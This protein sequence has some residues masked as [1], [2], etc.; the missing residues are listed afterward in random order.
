[1]A[2]SC[3]LRRIKG[4]STEQLKAIMDRFCLYVNREDGKE[5]TR[6]DYIREILAFHKSLSPGFFCSMIGYDTIRLMRKVWKKGERRDGQV[7]YPGRYIYREDTPGLWDLTSLALADISDEGVSIDETVFR[8]IQGIPREDLEL[9]KS[10]EQVY[11]IAHRYLLFWGIVDE[12]TLVTA[13]LRRLG[14]NSSDLRPM[15][16]EVILARCGSRSVLRDDDRGVFYLA[17]EAQDDDELLSVVDSFL[18][19]KLMYAVPSD[20]DLLNTIRLDPESLSDDA[21]TYLRAAC[22]RKE[23]PKKLM[24]KPAKDVVLSLLDSSGSIQIG[25][26][27]LERAVRLLRQNIRDEAWAILVGGIGKNACDTG[28]AHYAIMKLVL[29]TPMWIYK[30]KTLEDLSTRPYSSSRPYSIMAV[31]AAM[32]GKHTPGFYDLCPCGSCRL[33][34]LCHGRGN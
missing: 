1:M 22:P 3:L 28:K 6:E 18:W 20:E 5:C 21:Y 26:D 23:I 25:L 24:E 16:Q 30:G 19:N 8:L 29:T 4:K 7:F 17:R 34:G 33:F 2:E 11:D 10:I 27:R 32:S 12:D 9:L 31:D 15:L 13:M 14:T